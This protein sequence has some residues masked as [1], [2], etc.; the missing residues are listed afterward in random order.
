MLT[1]KGSL[2]FP[3]FISD[4]FARTTA[5]TTVTDRS[6]LILISISV[7]FRTFVLPTH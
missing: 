3:F 4:R 6:T 7:S 1:G 2:P 5:I